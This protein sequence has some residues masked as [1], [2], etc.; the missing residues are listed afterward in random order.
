MLVSKKLIHNLTF[1]P[2]Y[3]PTPP[4]TKKR[5]SSFDALIQVAIDHAKAEEAKEAREAK[6][7]AAA[8]ANK[9]NDGQQGK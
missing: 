3:K 6:A 9:Q 4:K 1:R 5:Q 8:E 2:L 7:R